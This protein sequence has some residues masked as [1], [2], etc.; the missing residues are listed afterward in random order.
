MGML[1]NKTAVVTGAA[2][3]IGRAVAR[4]FAAEGARVFGLDHDAAGL[5]SVAGITGIP[6]DITDEASVASAF[7]QVGDVDV[8]VANAGIQLFGRDAAIADLE[9]DVWRRT[10][11]VNLTGTF[12]TVKHAVRSMQG[13]GGSI[14]VTGSPT[15]LTGIGA[16]FTA[17]STSKAGVHGLTRTVATAY[18][19]AGIRINTVVPGHTATPLV[20]TIVED[21]DATAKM[22]ARIPLGRRGTTDDVEG[23]MLFLASDASAYATGGTF[24]VDGGLTI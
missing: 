3:G 23:I 21:A 2:S 17:Y 24:V 16:S 6:V 5:A 13:R 7:A 20:S 18:A 22:V 8:V 9:L 14:I 1:D 12:L 11:D 10:I 4:R 15:G 19:S